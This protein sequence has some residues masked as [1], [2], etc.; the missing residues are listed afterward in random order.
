MTLNQFAAKVFGL[1]AR[2]TYLYV[3]LIPF[4]N[5]TFAAI[6]TIPLPAGGSWTPIS[7]ITGLIL[8]VRDFAQREVGHWIFIPLMVAI[9]LSFATSDPAVAIASTCAF[10]ISEI[11]DWAIYTFVRRPLSQRVVISTAISAPL[12]SAVFY[13]IASLSIVGIFNIWTVGTSVLS[14]LL[15]VLVVF[16]ILRERERRQ[17]LS[18]QV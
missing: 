3:A 9:A 15:G 8:V 5:W 4:V 17:A 10:A 7:V 16:L 13:L 14:K 18:P 6:P 11:V 1:R 12:D 2:W